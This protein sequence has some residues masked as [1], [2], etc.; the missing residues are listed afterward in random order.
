MVTDTV[1]YE[2]AAI[3]KILSVSAPL[4]YISITQNIRD[5]I[6]AF[7]QKWNTKLNEWTADPG[8]LLILYGLDYTNNPEDI[9]SHGRYT[10]FLKNGDLLEQGQFDS[11][12]RVG[13]WFEY[14]SDQDILRKQV[15]KEGEKHSESFFHLSSKNRPY[16]GKFKLNYTDGISEIVKVKKGQRHG[17][18]KIID[19]SGKI[20][21]RRKYSDGLLVN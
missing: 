11:D 6:F 2:P 13:D 1:N 14:Y 3:L 17:V 15:Y 5:T 10:V 7:E 21:K 9:Q 16:S 19:Q 8:L 20:I 12:K 4:Y 18:T